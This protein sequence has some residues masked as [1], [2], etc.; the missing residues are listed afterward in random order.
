MGGGWGVAGGVL[1]DEFGVLKKETLKLKQEKKPLF[2]SQVITARMP[3]P[4]ISD[5]GHLFVRGGEQ[6]PTLFK[7]VH[8]SSTDS[9]GALSWCHL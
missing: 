4:W 8:L 7:Y 9:S 1:A 2:L 3:Q 5:S 6:A